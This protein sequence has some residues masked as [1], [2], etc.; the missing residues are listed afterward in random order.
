MSY[1]ATAARVKQTLARKGRS[2]FTLRK[3]SG[4]GTFNPVTGAY[5]TAQTQTDHAVSGVL[6]EI[7]RGFAQADQSGSQVTR[8][9]AKS[10]LV[11]YDGIIQNGDRLIV[12]TLDY[13]VIAANNINP[14]NLT[15]VVWELFLKV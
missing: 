12:D 10:A 4:T 1:V 5:T 11:S 15:D 9:T 7:P 14:D 3:I 8:F 6:L 13:E 2:D